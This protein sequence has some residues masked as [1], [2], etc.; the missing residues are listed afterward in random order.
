[1][2]V[3]DLVE[4]IQA[5]HFVGDTL[6]DGRPVPA[7]GELLRHDGELELCARGL[8]ASDRV[9]DALLYAPGN[10]ICR[11]QIGGKILRGEDKLCASERTILWRIDA[12]TLLFEFA[13]WAALQVVH[14]W[15]CPE[16]VRTYLETGDQEIKEAAR[17][18]AR[19]VPRSTA[20]NA[21]RYATGYDEMDNVWD[22]ARNVA[23]A[24]AKNA[25]R[26]S[27]KNAAMD[28]A[29]NAARTAQNNKITTMILAA[30]DV[31]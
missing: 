20:W 28:D 29:W 26:A 23:N 9:I 15:E 12:E 4:P 19:S 17:D 11:V 10:T 16:V 25:A 27:A 21:A 30:R 31:A 22:V 7:D 1:M 18:A 5:W 8:H 2:T 3:T 24:A 6:R 13:R 14:L